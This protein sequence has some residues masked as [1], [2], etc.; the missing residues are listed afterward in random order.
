MTGC[1]QDL[2]KRLQDQLNEKRES[3]LW[4]KML[5]VAE[6][7]HTR[8]LQVELWDVDEILQE[9]LQDLEFRPL[10]ETPL[11]TLTFCIQ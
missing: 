5:F 10:V 3:R 2:V 6:H 8:R 7:E 11:V 1:L 9:E 4:E